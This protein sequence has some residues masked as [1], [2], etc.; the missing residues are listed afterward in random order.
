MILNHAAIPMVA[1]AQE[2][3]GVGAAPLGLPIHNEPVY[4]P[5]PYPR[6]HFSF[7][8]FGTMMKCR[9]VVPGRPAVPSIRLMFSSLRALRA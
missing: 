9:F 4:R 6:V 2:L 7:V 1:L 3:F 5:A 8:E